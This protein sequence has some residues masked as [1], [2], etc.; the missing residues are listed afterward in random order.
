MKRRDSRNRV[1]RP[2]EGQLQNGK[3]FYKYYENRKPKYLYSWKL[4]S[5]DPLPKGKRPCVPLRD[6]EKAISV[7]L[8]TGI[9]TCGGNMSVLQLVERYIALRSVDVKEN[10]KIGY[11]TIR[12]ILIKENIF[13]H[14]RIDQ[15]RVSDAKSFL[16]RMYKDYHM[17]RSTI[18]SIRGV[19]RPAFRT[20]VNDDLIIRNPFEFPLSEIIKE[21][22]KEK[23][24]LTKSQERSFLHFLKYDSHYGEFYPGIYI[25]LKMGLRV[26]EFCALTVQSIN[27]NHMTLTINKQLQYRGKNH[28][29]IE[30]TKTTAGNR[31]IPIPPD[32][33]LVRCFELLLNKPRPKPDPEV[34]GVSGFLYFSK[35]GKPLVGYQWT[36]KLIYASK[37]YNALYKEAIPVVT[38][39]MLRHTCSSRLWAR[40]LNVK[41][42]SKFLG[43]SSVN[44][45][46]DTY[47]HAS[48]EDIRADMN[49]IFLKK[50]KGC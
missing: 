3:Y 29:W 23:Q 16:I 19:L 37:S 11:R 9:S 33:E 14:R 8:D 40:G 47:T 32:E 24:I 1:L 45:T 35:N 6:Q 10:T 4:V 13:C 7:K 46:M 12:N 39:H 42:I 48:T 44:I 18:H 5:T 36:K 28:Y 2:R 31:I 38:S 25:M 43:H 30:D 26:S 20:A 15:V 21:P 34:D 22:Y 41:S 27:L 17:S 50:N 49:K